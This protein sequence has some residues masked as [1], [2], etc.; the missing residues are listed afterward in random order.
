MAGQG[1]EGRG[2][3]ERGWSRVARHAHIV[4]DFGTAARIEVAAAWL[5]VEIE[6]MSAMAFVRLRLIGVNGL[7]ALKQP[8]CMRRKIRDVPSQALCDRI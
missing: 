2:D 6:P 8:V 3:G 7:R 5:K 4:S 1:G